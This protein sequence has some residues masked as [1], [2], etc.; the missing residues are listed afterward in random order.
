MFAIFWSLL[1]YGLSRLFRRNDLADVLWGPGFATVC[2]SYAFLHSIQLTERSG[3]ILVLVTLWGFRLAVYLGRRNLKKGEDF[4]YANWR[5]QWGRTEPWRAYLQIFFLQSLILI[6]LALPWIAHLA[7][8]EQ[9]WGPWGWLGTSIFL[10]G[11][12][13]EWVADSQ[14]QSHRATFPAGTLLSTGLW[15]WVRHPNYQG[16]IIMAWGLYISALELPWGFTLIGSPLLITYLL[17]RVSGVPMLATALSQRS[18]E[19][20]RYVQ[21]T[22]ALWSLS[23]STRIAIRFLLSILLLIC[24]DAAWLGLLMKGFYTGLLYPVARVTAQGD[25]DPWYPAVLGVYLALA[26]GIQ[27]LVLPGCRLRMEAFARGGLFGLIVY[28][29]YEMTNRSLVAEWPSSVV[30]TDMAWGTALCALTA[31]ASFRPQPKSASRATAHA[32]PP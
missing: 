16:E 21:S 31:A 3:L 5:K 26:L 15:R 22:P 29:V 20:P 18:P 2:A 17:A 24:L 10:L 1:G 8:A 32:P 7:F 6:F 23:G 30:A 27:T 4:R 25:W 9:P 19:F 12:G 13:M 11:M 14:L 28:A